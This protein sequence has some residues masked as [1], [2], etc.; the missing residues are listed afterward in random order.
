M[1]SMEEKVI[2][3][4]SDI[5]D[6]SKERIMSEDIEWEDAASIALEFKEWLE[7]DEIELLYLDNDQ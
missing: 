5:I 7:E 6:W 1:K 4:I 3:C 2:D